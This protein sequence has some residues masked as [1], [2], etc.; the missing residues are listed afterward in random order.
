MDSLKEESERLAAEHPD[1]ADDI[2]KK[3]DEITEVWEE[4]RDLLKKRED[5]LGEAGNLQKFLQNLDAFQ[6]NFINHLMSHRLT[7]C[8]Y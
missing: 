5:S 4:L 3:Y 1:D 8:N 6:V 2:H 7:L